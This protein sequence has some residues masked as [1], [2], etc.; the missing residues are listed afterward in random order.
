M[1]KKI[2]WNLRDII[3]DE[4]EFNSIL[5]EAKKDVEKLV[6]FRKRLGPGMGAEAFKELLLLEESLDG[7]L[8]RLGSYSGLI[9]SADIKSQKAMKYY[10]ILENLSMEI[11]DKTRFISHW[12]KGK[13]IEGLEILDDENAKRLFRAIP[14][15]EYSLS[16]SR[17]DGKHTLTEK[18]ESIIH[19]KE[20][21]GIDT[22]VELYDKI[23]NDF[24]FKLRVEGRTKTVKSLEQLMKLT[25]S[26]KQEERKGAYLGMLE[27]YRNNREKLFSIYSSIVKNWKID[28]ELRNFK[29]PIS[30]RNFGNHVS[31]EVIEAVLESCKDNSRIFHRY[32]EKKARMLGIEKLQRYDVYAPLAS[33]EREYSYEDAKSVVFESMGNFNDRFKEKAEMIIRERHVDV[34][35]RKDKRNGAF[36]AEITPKIRPYVLLNYTGKRRDVST[37]A[38]ELGHGIHDIYSSRLPISV[39]HPTL[40]LAETASTFCELLLFEDMLNKADEKQKIAMLAERIGEDYATTVRQSYFVMFEKAAHGKI[41]NENINEEELSQ[42]YYEITKQ[43]FGNSIEFNDEFR[44]E[45]SYIPHI[46]HTPFYCYSYSFGELLSLSLY[47]QYKKEGKDFIERIE[48]ILSSGGSK[49]PEGLLKE[50]GFDI[51]DRKFWDSGFSLING[52]IDEIR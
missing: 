14:E 27:T 34:Y 2:E 23:T 46:F 50:V 41:A 8:A 20:I 19:K 5:S 35:P 11:A 28:A 36:C 39:M 24:E 26:P 45:W 31:D 30:I 4:E 12:I 22:V 18:E 48:H 1:A 9:S 17:L 16:Y 49:D 44:H 38:H 3:K 32:F 43:Q 33:E 25:H 52:W 42:L 15:L 13:K 51:K 37:L 7:K 21:V 29:S 10:S 6:L 47:S 40:P